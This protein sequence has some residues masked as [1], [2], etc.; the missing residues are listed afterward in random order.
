MFSAFKKRKI[1]LITALALILNLGAGCSRHSDDDSED[2]FTPDTVQVSMYLSS[3]Y[4]PPTTD[5]DTVANL[6]RLCSA[7]TLGDAVSSDVSGT[8]TVTFTD[9]TTGYE[10][11]YA[12]CKDGSVSIDGGEYRTGDDGTLYTQVKAAYDEM[13]DVQELAEKL[14]ALK[15]D[16]IG[17][18][19]SD[20]AILAALGVEESL[21]PY[22]LE[23][24]TDTPPYGI[25]LHLTNGDADIPAGDVD[26]VM[27]RCGYLF[28]ALVQNAEHFSWYYSTASGIHFG[29]VSASDY[30]I[31]QCGESLE[32]F[33]TLCGVIDNLVVDKSGPEE[34]S[35]SSGSDS[36]V[37][38][39][40]PT[41]TIDSLWKMVQSLELE[42][43]PVEP[44][45]GQAI[46]IIF[47]DGNGEILS[48]W[49]F[50]GDY[51]RRDGSAEYYRITGGSIS[52][53][54]IT[55][56]YQTSK[57]SADYVD[58]YYVNSPLFAPAD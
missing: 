40:A 1:L 50:F 27:G 2:G 29:S 42:E 48:T 21:G 6:Y 44:D 9:S 58:G 41:D 37:M 32:R 51:C 25:R 47:Y 17:D 49:S 26:T 45:M 31:D 30:D 18:A 13:C 38:Y 5:E 12:L 43:A 7:L 8:L 52:L 55:Y 33:A 34:L 19:S 35:L 11:D 57:D 15:S 22:T 4:C 54:T 20:A 53:Q 10:V 56:I 39:G 46:N 3:F 16:Y 36:Y 24:L 28:L 23:L 14:Y